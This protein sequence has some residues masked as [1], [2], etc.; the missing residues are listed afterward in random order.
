MS[1]VIKRNGNVVP[2]D[3]LK[4]TSAIRKAM[5]ECNVDSSNAE[6]VTEDVVKKLDDEYV[7]IEDIQ[8]EVEDSLMKLGFR[9]VAKSYILYRQK[10]KETRE[11]PIDESILGI[12]NRNNIEVLTENSNKQGEIVSTQRD[13]MAG[14]VSKHLAK[15]KMIPKDIIDAHN[16]GIIHI[17]DLDYYA[18][19]E[20]NCCL[21]P[22]KDM[23]ENGFVLNK[24]MIRKPKSLRTASTLATQICQIV[25]SSQYGGQTISLSHLAPYVRVSENKIREELKD[26]LCI[27]NCDYNNDKI[28]E[29]VQL[30]L[31]KEIKD[32]VQTFN[33]QIN[34]MNSSNGQAPFVS[35]CMYLN[36]EPEYTKETAMLIEEFLNQ[37]IKGLENQF[38]VTSTQTFPKLLYFLDENNMYKDSEYYYLTQLA[39]KSTSLRMNPDFISVKRMKELVGDAFPC[40]N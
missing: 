20:T 9:D 34:T 30:R 40:I 21:V 8:D 3:K 33:Y 37:R 18:N 19:P 23:F 17:H 6:Y 15:T 27:L 16:K 25:S 28:E 4:I 39:I 14:E 22:L 24:K 31:K 7:E 5:V 32:A 13:L 1:I 26:E 35:V 12:L 38:G 2:F 29:I 11:H 10:R 36:E